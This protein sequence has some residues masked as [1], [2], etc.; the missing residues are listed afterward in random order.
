M[1]SLSESNNIIPDIIKLDTQG[2]ELLILK[3]AERTLSSAIFVEIETEFHEFYIGQPTFS[4]VHKFMILNGFRLIN[5]NPIEWSR[6]SDLDLE[7][8]KE[9]IFCDS[10]YFK[11][12]NF[13]LETGLSNNNEKTILK[14]IL[15][16]YNLNFSNYSFFIFSK[17]RSFLNSD[18]VNQLDSF[19]RIE[20]EI[21]Q[22]RKIKYEKRIK[23]LNKMPFLKVL[24]SLYRRMIYG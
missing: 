2:S 9:L 17:Y 21:Y 23:F 11:D 20:S 18:L 22:K 10:L 13:S 24:K 4:E 8:R 5:I 7:S 19:F 1:D 14:S 16:S 3:G 6:N 15:I 12:L